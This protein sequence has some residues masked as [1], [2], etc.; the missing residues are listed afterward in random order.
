MLGAQEVGSVLKTKPTL[1]DIF[2]FF[3]N[4]ISRAIIPLLFAAALVI[5]IWGVIQYMMSA[6]DQTKR[7]EGKKFIMWGIVSL[8]VMTAIWG[9]LSILAGTFGGVE[10]V[11][12]QLPQT[13]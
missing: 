1:K 11:I 8:F 3:A 7:E 13:R 6:N 12:P 4:L 2:L 5:F 10:F 9:I